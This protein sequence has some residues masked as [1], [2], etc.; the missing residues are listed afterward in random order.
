MKKKQPLKTMDLLLVLL[1][2]VGIVLYWISI[3]PNGYLL[4]S[5]LIAMTVATVVRLLRDKD[6]QFKYSKWLLIVIAALIVLTGID[7][8]IF[9][10]LNHSIFLISYIFF[11]LIQPKPAWITRP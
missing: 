2:L 9:K 8:M 11:I 7:R 4:Y 10:E 6:H 5:S 1:V 3:D